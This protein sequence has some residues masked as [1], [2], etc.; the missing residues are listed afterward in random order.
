MHETSQWDN[1]KFDVVTTST[2]K[3]QTRHMDVFLLHAAALI[4]CRG[5]VQEKA[6]LLAQLITRQFNS[7]SYKRKIYWENIYLKRAIKFMFYLC[8]VLP[9]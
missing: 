1:V 4:L 7:N 6:E 9:Y 5:E 3:Y 8:V 2:S